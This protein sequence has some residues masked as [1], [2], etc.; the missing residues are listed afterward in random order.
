MW[1]IAAAAAAAG[2]VMVMDNGDRKDGQR[3]LL[4]VRLSDAEDSSTVTEVPQT[5]RHADC[6]A[7]C[8]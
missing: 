8:C 3:V 5:R 2:P 1:C 6:Q 4:A 7:G